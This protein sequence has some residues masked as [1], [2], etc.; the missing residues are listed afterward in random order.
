MRLY[1]TRRILPLSMEVLPCQPD[2]AA[3]VLQ[4]MDDGGRL[5]DHNAVRRAGGSDGLSVRDGGLPDRDVGGVLPAIPGA[6]A[7]LLQ[8]RAS[9]QGTVLFGQRGF[10]LMYRAVCGGSGLG[11]LPVQTTA[12]NRR[13]AADPD[14]CRR[15]RDHGARDRQARARGGGA[16]NQRGALPHLCRC[17]P[18]VVLDGECGWLDLDRKST[19]LNSS[20]RCISYAVFCLK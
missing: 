14:D 5:A 20:H 7:G 8:Q 6:K 10:E 16:E 11:N 15:R 12:E 3:Y 18:A 4:V 1:C 13:R 19:R 17:N 9:G 2:T